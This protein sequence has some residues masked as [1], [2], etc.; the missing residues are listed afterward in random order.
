MEDPDDVPPLVADEARIYRVLGGRVSLDRSRGSE[1]PML[2]I[3]TVGRDAAWVSNPKVEAWVKGLDVG[4]DLRAEWT[5]LWRLPDEAARNRVR[6]VMAAAGAR[7]ETRSRSEPPIADVREAW[8]QFLVHPR[9]YRFS[10]RWNAHTFD[11]HYRPDTDDID[12]VTERTNP[13]APLSSWEAWVEGL[14]ASVRRDRYAED[15]ETRV[16]LPIGHPALPDALAPALS[17]TDDG[18]YSLSIDYLVR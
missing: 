13:N 5:G 10:V 14:P 18:P 1:L 17:E 3:D 8:A 16:R 7:C 4:D 15:R 11:T 2:R 9:R 6:R 12:V